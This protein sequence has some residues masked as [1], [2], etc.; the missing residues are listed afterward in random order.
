MVVIFSSFQ[1]PFFFF[2]LKLHP[3]PGGVFKYFLFSLLFGEIPILTNIFQM[4]WNHQP[5]LV[6]ILSPENQLFLWKTKRRFLKAATGAS[7]SNG[8]SMLVRE[9]QLVATGLLATFLVCVPRGLWSVVRLFWNTLAALLPVQIIKRHDKL[10]YDWFGK[11]EAPPEWFVCKRNGFL[12]HHQKKA[13]ENSLDLNTG[14]VKPLLIGKTPR[15]HKT[16]SRKHGATRRVRTLQNMP[17][18]RWFRPWTNRRDVGVM[19]VGLRTS[20]GGLEKGRHFACHFFVGSE[21]DS[22]ILEVYCI[23]ISCMVTKKQVKF[24]HVEL[25]WLSFFSLFFSQCGLQFSLFF[26]I[27]NCRGMTLTVSKGCFSQLQNPQ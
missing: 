13:R 6:S 10:M 22:D 20:Q 4:G 19:K 3:S 2:N 23:P 21:K 11:I 9:A 14:R 27:L 7:E 8:L 16:S 5:V 26:H 18:G 15:N 12:H 1:K 25:R 24:S 17:C